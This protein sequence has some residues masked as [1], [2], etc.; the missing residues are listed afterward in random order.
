MTRR[1]S[2]SA[3]TF[4][5]QLVCIQRV[6]QQLFKGSFMEFLTNFP[7]FQG[8]VRP[9]LSQRASALESNDADTKR[10]IA[11]E[12]V[13][14]S[15]NRNSQL[16]DALTIVN[17]ETTLPKKQAPKLLVHKQQIVN[18]EDLTQQYNDKLPAAIRPFIMG[19]KDVKYDGNC[20]FRAI[21]GLLGYEKNSWHKSVEIKREV[22]YCFPS[23]RQVDAHTRNGL[24]YCKLLQCD[25]DTFFK[26]HISYVSTNGKSPSPEYQCQETA[27]GLVE[28]HF[29]HVL[30]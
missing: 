28:K 4:V 23:R 22:E 5:E 8:V 18:P 14:S 19:A 25:L 10:H 17:V 9:L 11:F 15:C 30:L 27:I 1:G 6:I 20:G 13:E 12:L 26:H 16:S 7:A 21:V 24:P 29:V 3:G 2:I